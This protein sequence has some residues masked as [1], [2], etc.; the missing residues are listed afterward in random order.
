MKFT[1]Y[2]ASVLFPIFIFAGPFGFDIGNK[3]SDYPNVEFT[4]TDKASWYIAENVPTP[5]KLMT[6][7]A[8]RA[9]ENSGICF[10]KA[11]SKTIKTS[12]YGTELNTQYENVRKSLANKYKFDFREE[13]T[14]FLMSGSL[15]D[16]PQ[17]YMMGLLKE[18]R[19][20]FSKFVAKDSANKI[21]SIF[22]GQNAES[23]ESGYL[24]LEYSGKNEQDCDDL[25]SL[26]D[27]DGF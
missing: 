13:K 10:I 12:K 18:E 1:F 6:V 17:Y 14:N 25:D 4:K 22:L 7:Y 19:F 16:D 27:A 8:V 23:T 2:L 20:K 24:A 11:M 3:L 26:D 9:T 21:Q 5:N 15:W